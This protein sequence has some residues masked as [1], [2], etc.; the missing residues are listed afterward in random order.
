MAL[1]SEAK[2]HRSTWSHVRKSGI[3]AWEM[4]RRAINIIGKIK[5]KSYRGKGIFQWAKCGSIK[6]VRAVI[7]KVNCSH[8][9]GVKGYMAINTEEA[10]WDWT[11][12]TDLLFLFRLL[13][14][15]NTKQFLKQ[16]ARFILKPRQYLHQE[17]KN[18]G[19]R[20]NKNYAL[21]LLAIA[22]VV[23]CGMSWYLNT[24]FNVLSTVVILWAKIF[25][26][27]AHK[28]LLFCTLPRKL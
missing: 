5:D 10:W 7:I 14:G 6:G 12:G 11:H 23:S 25:C 16:K 1:L 15:E 2:L 17:E 9:V 18:Q 19:Q 21:I 4:Q 26:R 22:C 13:E 8:R 28:L 20:T 27:T 3:K 24:Y